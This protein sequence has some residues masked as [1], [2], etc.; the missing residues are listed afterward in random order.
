M[1]EEISFDK[2]WRLLGLAKSR[3]DAVKLNVSQP[4]QEL[5]DKYFKSI[6][7]ISILKNDGFMCGLARFSKNGTSEKV[8]QLHQKARIEQGGFFL[9]CFDGPLVQIYEKQGFKP[10]AIIDFNE[11]FAPDGWQDDLTLSKK[12]AIV[13]MSLRHDSFR[14]KKFDTYMAA[15]EYT[16]NK[17]QE[18]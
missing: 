8:A 2:Y 5:G 1:I 16:K 3:F 10:V 6:Q 4:E 9:E 11:E 15:Y 17:K 7:G 18:L 13:F 14:I 12:P